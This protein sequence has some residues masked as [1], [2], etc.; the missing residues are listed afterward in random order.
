MALSSEPEILRSDLTTALLQLKCVGQDMEEI[1][2]M[3]P[4][5]QQSCEPRFAPATPLSFH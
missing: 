3:D 5:D 1:E 2:F 4:P